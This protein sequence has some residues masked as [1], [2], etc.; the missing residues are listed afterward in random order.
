VRVAPLVAFAFV[1]AAGAAP[2]LAQG[3]E[4]KDGVNVAI[5]RFSA[6]ARVDEGVAL[7]EVDETFRNAESVQRE[8]VWRFRLPADAVVSSF[9]MWMNG[10]EKTGR[11]LE[12]TQARR[13]YDSI[14][15]R[16]KD[17]GLLEQTGWRDF[18]V[19][20]FPIPANDT[21]RIRLRYAYVLPDDLG[22]ETLEVPLPAGCGR[23]GDLRA[24]AAF[25]AARG[26]ASLDC[27]S[28][29]DAKVACAEGRGEASWTGDGIEAARAFVVRAV[30]KRD[31]FDVAVLVSK[32]PEGGEGWFVA[33]VVPRLA[34]PHAIP[35]DVEFVVDRSGSMNGPKIEQARAALLRGIDSLRPGDR[36]DV[37]SFSS[38]VTSLGGGA[39]LPAD[40]PSLERA[41]RAAKEISASGGT[42]I[43]GA[44]AAAAAM[45]P[46]DP[47]RLFAVVFLTDGDPTVG[48]TNPDR[49]LA[50]WR[51]DA[52]AARLFAFGVGADVREFLLT[53][54]AAEGRGL[55]AYVRDDADL[56]VKVSSLVDSIRTP[57]LVDPDVTV[58]GDG[59]EIADREPQ[60]LPDVF[61]GRALVVTG[62][63]RG[64]G[65]A[66]LHLRGRGSASRVDVAVP[67]DLT[68]AAERPH[69]A[70]IWAKQRVERLLDDLRANGANAEVKAEIVRLGTRFQIVSP[71]TSFLV[72]E[73][74]VRIPD[75]GEDARVPDAPGGP[76]TAGVADAGGAAGGPTGGGGGGGGPTTGGGPR[77][78]AGEVPPDAREPSDPPPDSGGPSTPSGDSGSPADSGGPSA[79]S[80]GGSGRTS[81]SSSAF[82]K[83]SPRLPGYEDWAH[84]WRA[85]WTEFA[86][87]ASHVDAADATKAMLRALVRDPGEHYRVRSA[88]AVSLG[89]MDDAD[90]VPDL[91]RIAKARDEQPCV[92]DHAILALGLAKRGTVESEVQALLLQ[93]LRGTAQDRDMP[94]AFAAIALGLRRDGAA[95]NAETTAAL[96]EIATGSSAADFG[97]RPACLV[98]LGLHGDQ[99]AIPDLVRCVAADETLGPYAVQALGRIGWPDSEVIETLTPCLDERVR[100]AVNVRRAAP[101]ALARLATAANADVQRR[102]VAALSASLVSAA[103]VTVRGR[104]AA[105]LGRIAGARATDAAVRAL[106]VTALTRACE[107]AKPPLVRSYAAIALG[108]AVRPES[109]GLNGKPATDV[110]ARLRAAFRG[111]A[112]GHARDA[113]AVAVEL[114]GDAVPPE[115]ASSLGADL[116]TGGFETL[117]ERRSPTALVDGL[118]DASADDW[119][120]RAAAFAVSRCGDSATVD[121]LAAVAADRDRRFGL[122]RACAV[123]AIGRI[124]G[125]FGPLDRATDGLECRAYDAALAELTSL[126]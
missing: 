96:R 74:G 31:G 49:I 102:M 120:L 112:D 103:D 12:A 48:E 109:G 125:D 33:R 9:S 47:S 43:A 117:V 73:D 68:A 80:G 98:A 16:R 99:A 46:S 72:V 41:R 61:Q 92:V 44:L 57:L 110:R 87:A 77:G 4:T 101:D 126:P 53:K 93:I 76:A 94:R 13:V 124:C 79:S 115:A 63:F 123:L 50:K 97:V 62:R 35:R 36:F 58:D 29:S 20:V 55:A 70:Q 104:A 118:T 17:P 107:S 6:D 100:V 85:A 10:A 54:L 119:R 84:W 39:L 1:A 88:A 51:D 11:V 15:R 37:I 34:D 113:F 90:S 60:R 105:A 81:G 111:E 19:S 82:G 26:L 56:E 28:H 52:G 71:Y 121:A 64:A 89:A 27:P 86:P 18:Q 108:I 106:A 22:L 23:I 75:A 66:T 59:V 91:M 32:S 7:V 21:V 122:A 38:D 78:P 45:R 95:A 3:L 114:G 24:H 40:A 2:C 5:E 83:R 69:V 67:L 65:K 30:P 25:A 116:R 42:N 14:V 8:G